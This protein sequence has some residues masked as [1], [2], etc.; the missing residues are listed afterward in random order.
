VQAGRLYDVL[1]RS[2]N[3][4][5]PRLDLPIR[6]LIERAYNITPTAEERPQ[7]S[8]PHFSQGVRWICRWFPSLSPLQAPN[9]RADLTRRPLGQ[10]YLSGVMGLLDVAM[11]YPAPARE[12]NGENNG[13]SSHSRLGMLRQ[14]RDSAL[15][16]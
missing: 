13:S 4:V 11:R 14:P 6:A 2:F 5:A 10:A 15:F 8:R 3:D 1:C 7:I 16:Q 12:P 9:L